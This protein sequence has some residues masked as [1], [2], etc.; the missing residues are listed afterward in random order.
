MRIE[1]KQTQ[2]YLMQKHFF[3]KIGISTLKQDFGQRT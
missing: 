3:K 1:T 2:I